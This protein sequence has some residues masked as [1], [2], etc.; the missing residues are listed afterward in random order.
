MTDYITGLYGAFGAVIALLAREK[1]GRGQWID[2]ALYECAFSFMEPWIPAYEKLGHVATRA[3]SRLPESTPNN[4]YPARDGQFIHIAAMG[5]AVFKRLAE[6]MGR[7]ELAG[8]RRFATAIARSEHHQQLDE[9]I[10]G[11]TSGHTLEELEATLGE[12]AVPATRIYTLADIFGDPHYRA[13]GTLVRAPDEDLGGVTMAQVVPRLSATPGA[14][15][16]AGHRVGQDT[17]SVLRDVLGLSPDRIE[18]LAGARIVACDG[19][20]PETSGSARRETAAR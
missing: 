7:P 11:W 15:R 10:A 14:V 18:A 19:P 12:A 9:L 16:H 13:R 1:T 3:G 20:R 17:W 4:L 8:D 6:A 2:A 5:D